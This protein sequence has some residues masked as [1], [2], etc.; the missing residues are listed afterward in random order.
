MAF[1]RSRTLSVSPL[2]IQRSHA[3]GASKS[4][5]ANVDKGTE[6]DVIQIDD[7]F[8]HVV[9]HRGRRGNVVHLV[10]RSWGDPLPVPLPDSCGVSP[11]SSVV[12]QLIVE[13]VSR[14]RS[15]CLVSARL[16]SFSTNELTAVGLSSQV[17]ELAGDA[18]EE[19]RCTWLR[20]AGA[21]RFWLVLHVMRGAL[22]VNGGFPMPKALLLKDS[23]GSAGRRITETTAWGEDVAESLASAIL[24]HQAG[25]DDVN[26]TQVNRGEGDRRMSVL[27]TSLLSIPLR[28]MLSPL[29]QDG[30]V[31]LEMKATVLTEWSPPQVTETDRFDLSKAATKAFELHSAWGYKEEQWASRHSKFQSLLVVCQHPPLIAL[32]VAPGNALLQGNA[33]SGARTANLG[34]NIDDVQRHETYPTLTYAH[35]ERWLHKATRVHGWH[36]M[37]IT[38]MPDLG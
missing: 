26:S 34:I 8:L 7:R 9:V 4:K 27:N 35:F 12:S 16:A 38:H 28:D 23:N 3:T 37:C 19:T 2:N 15:L 5:N 32:L 24:K 30:S 20:H 6:V 17:D 21:E 25:I 33:K 22:Y 1:T 11:P 10:P 29:L 14:W 13:S 18:P 36:I 31:L